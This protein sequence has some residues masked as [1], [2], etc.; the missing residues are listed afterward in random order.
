MLYHAGALDDNLLPISIKNKSIFNDSTWF[1][2]WDEKDVEANK[3]ELKPGTNKM[4][5]MVNIK[6][7]NCFLFFKKYGF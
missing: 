2:H 3:Y 5:R 6:V 7:R 1:P 4:K